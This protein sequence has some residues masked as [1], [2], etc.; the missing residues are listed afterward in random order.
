MR[1]V[2]WAAAAAGAVLLIAGCGSEGDSAQGHGG[3]APS[4]SGSAPAKAGSG[5]SLDVAAVKKEIEA[6]A[7]PGAVSRFT[8]A[9]NS[10][11]ANSAG[12]RPRAI[13]VRMPVARMS[14]GTRPCGH[15]EVSFVEGVMKVESALER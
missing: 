1:K 8:D 2:R 12:D 7:M 14:G 13:R 15:A 9:P 10:P 5:G 4:A 6:A 3:D 11:A